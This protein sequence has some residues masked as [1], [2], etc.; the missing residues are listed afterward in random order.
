MTTRP[1]FDY[2]NE[3]WAAKMIGRRNTKG[4]DGYLGIEVERF[5]PGLLVAGFDVGPDLVT[6]IGNIHG[7]CISVLIDHVLGVIL[8][9]LM[10]DRYW[11]AT[12]E[13]KTNL[14]A[15]VSGGRVRAT[16]EVVSMT[17]RLAVVRIDV[18]NETETPAPD[19][20]GGEPTRSTRLVAIAQ[21]T[22]TIVAP[23][24]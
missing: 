7:G 16:A 11:A 1:T 24:G 12:T 6:M 17:K 20:T 23:K 2:F 22:C 9:P 8:Y 5:E 4:V 21:G 10:P 15:P 3:A 18:E 14:L 13:F 19:G